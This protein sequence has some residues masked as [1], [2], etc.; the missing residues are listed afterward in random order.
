MVDFGGSIALSFGMSALL[1]L[2]YYPSNA[3]A[4]ITGGVLVDKYGTARVMLVCGA[5]LLIGASMML[6]A[7]TTDN[8][9]LVIAGL[10]VAGLSYGFC[11]VQ[12]A[13]SMR[14][15]FGPKSFA[16]N[17]GYVQTSILLAAFGG[18]LAGGMLDRRE[19]DFS[20]VFVLLMCLAVAGIAAGLGMG[21]YLKR[22]RHGANELRVES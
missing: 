19:G 16:Q 1:G 5:T 4:N 11:L 2:L 3:M 14:F 20:V 12:S 10:L 9:V 21:Q 22:R 15:L 7:N 13:T 18:Y 17:F 6:F 8:G